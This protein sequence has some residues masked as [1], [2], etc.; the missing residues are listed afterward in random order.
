MSEEL[1]GIGT[2]VYHSE[3]GKGVVVEV[4]LSTYNV[5]FK[6]RGDKEIP[7][8]DSRMRVENLVEDKVTR[9]KVEEVEAVLTSILQKWSDV[10]GTVD[11]G[12]K[13]V[14]G[15]LSLQPANPDLKPKE[16]PIE[17]FFHKIVMTRDRLRVMEQK[18]NGS[19][20]LNDEEKVALQQYLTK[21]YGSLTT[22]NVLF[23]TPEDHFRGSGG[24]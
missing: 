11:L 12:K 24:G 23:D 6:E 15:M 13:W 1:L 7:H 18:I 17:T 10:G 5:F 3:F 22:F 2:Q 16:I 9:L 19:K 20:N 14:G 4:N 21:I 8:L